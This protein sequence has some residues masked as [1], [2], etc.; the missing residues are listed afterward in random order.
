MD[1]ACGLFHILAL[2]SDGAVVG[3]GQCR[4]GS[5]AIPPLPLG[6]VYTGIASGLDHSLLLRSDGRLLAIGCQ[7]IGSIGCG[8]PPLPAGVSYVECGASSYTSWARR[9][10]GAVVVFGAMFPASTVFT[11]SG[12]THNELGYG[13]LPASRVGAASTYVTVAAGCAGSL[14]PARLVPRD[15]PRLGAVLRVNVL[16]VPVDAAFLSTWLGTTV[17]PF[18][19]LPLDLTPF[20]MPGCMAR[21]GADAVELV[22]GQNRVAQFAMAVPN[23]LALVGVTFHQQAFVPDPTAGNPLG[24]VLSEATRARIGN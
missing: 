8:V 6:L 10:D 24:A 7:G 19:P 18:G 20:G 5:C 21:V 11:P 1:A 17:G 12:V 16:D 4:G 13:Q 9:S 3:W 2:R 15:T 14:P 23:T 22:T